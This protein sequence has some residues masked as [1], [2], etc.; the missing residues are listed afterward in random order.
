MFKKE[1]A[2]D[3]YIRERHTQEE[4]IGF[5]DG[6]ERCQK[7]M[8]DMKYTEEDIRKA[9]EAGREQSS[10]MTWGD[11]WVDEFRYDTFEDWF[12]KDK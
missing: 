8:S 7:D 4:C 9:F 10:R 11:E 3:N 6:Y 5:I 2:V 12:D 1:I